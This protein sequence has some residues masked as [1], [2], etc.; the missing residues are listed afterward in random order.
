MSADRK[1]HFHSPNSEE[2]S[3]VMSGVI[4]APERMS[5]I[6][7]GFRKRYSPRQTRKRVVI[8]SNGT[9]KCTTPRQPKPKQRP[10]SNSQAPIAVRPPLPRQ[11]LGDRHSRRRRTCKFSNADM[12][13]R[14]TSWKRS[15]GSTA[16]RTLMPTYCASLGGQLNRSNGVRPAE[17]HF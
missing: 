17:H 12:R 3:I 6:P 11:A 16:Q 7:D 4:S 10:A 14:L 5:D 2:L 9:T 8:S 1:H 13:M 15:R